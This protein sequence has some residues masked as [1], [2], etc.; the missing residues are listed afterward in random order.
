MMIKTILLKVRNPQLVD[1]EAKDQK[2]RGPDFLFD[3]GDLVF[4]V[5]HFEYDATKRMSESTRNSKS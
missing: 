3:I 1:F 5:E 4:V 2:V